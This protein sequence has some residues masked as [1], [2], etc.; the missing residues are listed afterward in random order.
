[1]RREG[2][3]SCLRRTFGAWPGVWRTKGETLQKGTKVHGDETRR[4]TTL[5][6]GTWRTNG[7]KAAERGKNQFIEMT[8]EGWWCGVIGYLANERGKAAKRL[9][10]KFI[11]MRYEGWRPCDWVFGERRGKAAERYTV[12][13]DETRMMTTVSPPVADIRGVTGRLENGG[14]KDT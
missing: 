2:W 11:E 4:M 14:G 3:P 12:H 1:M 7:G 6:L 5:W 9:K 10:K 13:W 8:C